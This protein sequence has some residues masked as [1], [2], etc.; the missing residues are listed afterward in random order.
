MSRWLRLAFVLL[1]LALTVLFV[2][3]GVWQVERLAEK[4]ALIATVAEGVASPAVP[5][6]EAADFRPVTVSGTYIPQSNVRVF[7]SLVD[8]RGRASGPGYWLLTAL[9]LENGGSIFVNRGFVPE[10]QS[11]E[12]AAA[13]VPQGR[14]DLE[15]LARQAEASGMF[16]PAATPGER[17]DWVRD[18]QRLALLVG[19]LPQPL[20]NFYLDLPASSPG[21][22]PQGGETVVE[23]PNNHL[24]YA[25]TWFGFAIL[26]PVLL[27][28]WLARQR[29]DRV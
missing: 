29:R 7:T 13:P 21:E 2:G 24:G 10:A 17:I 1:M 6:S 14:Q 25:I 28:F 18:P 5:L 26:T 15:G 11:A 22:L 23:F 20:S 4:E 19:N 8:P 9:A 12:L 3:L 27:G 16:T